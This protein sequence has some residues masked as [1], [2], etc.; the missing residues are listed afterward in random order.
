M[1]CTKM[2]KKCHLVDITVPGDKRI[3]L[4]EQEKID[5]YTELRQESEKDLELVSSCGC[6]IY[7]WR[8]RSDIK[9]IERLAGEVKH[10]E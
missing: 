4:K 5:N 6:S 7:N 3:E 8:P 9:K 2:E 1:C 10:K